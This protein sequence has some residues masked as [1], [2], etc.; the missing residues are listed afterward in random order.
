MDS[1]APRTILVVDDDQ[2]LLRLIER[3][4]RREGFDTATATSGNDA[5]TWLTSNS[6][7]LLLLDL[8][9]QDIEAKELVSHLADMGRAIPFII[10]TGQ[11]DERVAVE[12]MK[13]GALDY[14]VKDVQFIEFV[15]TVV[16]RALAQLQ[17]DKRL[18]LAE[19][20]A[21]ELGK[22]LAA[23][24]YSISH[25]LRAPLRAINSFAHML[26]EQM[27]GALGE[28]ES[29]LLKVISDSSKKMGEMVDGFL[30]L[31]RTGQQSMN[32]KP[33][34]MAAL[35][36]DVVDAWRAV[37]P[38]A[39]ARFQVGPLPEAIGDPVLLRQVW[40]NLLENALKFSAA[41]HPA[42]ITVGAHQTEEGVVY[43]VRDNGVGF[44][45]R[46]SNKLFGVFQRLHREDEFA[47]YGLGLASVQRIVHK[48]GGKV[49][50]EA[51]PGMG[52]TFH[53]TV[54]PKQL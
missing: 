41:R 22:E 26:A 46:Y 37:A 3:A 53:F 1:N 51:E 36:Q 21:Q 52:A 54:S 32:R 50:A 38:Q 7:D 23:F 29:R 39:D 24:S 11:G 43:F 44:D 5:I 28:D 19:K 4:L 49:W 2:G 14:L 27:G 40:T 25:D 8:K 12:M 42:L 15:P 33:V 9:L 31:T 30:A 18:A 20:Q 34:D 48:H 10:I 16:K 47:G 17:K 35:V 45:P 6:A 13:R